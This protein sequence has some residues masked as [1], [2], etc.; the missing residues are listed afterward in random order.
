MTATDSWLV[1]TSNQRWADT[2]ETLGSIGM[3]FRTW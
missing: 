1:I 2:D 3:A